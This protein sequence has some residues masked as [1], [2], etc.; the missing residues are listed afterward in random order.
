M[1]DDSD[2][3]RGKRK[4][5]GKKRKLL[6]GEEVEVLSFDEGL[7]GSWHLAV[8]VACRDSCRWVEYTNLLNDNRSSKLVESIAVSAAIE[9]EREVTSKYRRGSIRPLPPR[10]S[11]QP[12][13]VRYGLCVD[14]LLD[15]AWWEG[16]V[17]DHREG[18]KERKVFF[19]DQGDQSIV[20]VDRLRVT[21][22][23]DEVSEEWKPRGEWLFLKVIQP[24]EEKDG[25]PVSIREIWYD[26]RGQPSFLRKI[27][28]WTSGT[29]LLWDRLVS[30]LIQELWS[31]DNGTYVP[32][33]VS[34]N[35]IIE[36]PR[37]TAIQLES[38]PS[39]VGIN[40]PNPCSLELHR[41]DNDSFLRSSM[42][43]PQ[44][45]CAAGDIFKILPECAVVDDP[46]G[47]VY[48][49]ELL[50]VS[51]QVINDRIYGEP[52]TKC[53]SNP[54]D[55]YHDTRTIL[56]HSRTW[57]PVKFEAEYSPEVA[58]LFACGMENGKFTP[59]IFRPGNNDFKLKL[60][61]HLLKLGW[62]IQFKRDT[63][64]RFRYFSPE[65]SCYYSLRQLCHKLMVGHQ[66]VSQRCRDYDK[67][68]EDQLGQT[69]HKKDSA[70][71]NRCPE[72]HVSDSLDHSWQMEKDRHQ[73]DHL[74][75]A[76][77][78][79]AAQNSEHVNGNTLSSKWLDS[80][81]P[82][83]SATERAASG[84][85]DPDWRET[86]SNDYIEP[87]YIP[88]AIPKYLDYI[89]SQKQA[90]GKRHPIGMTSLLRL[91]AKKH[92][93]S[94]GWK[95]SR[96]SKK[97]KKEM[98][99]SSPEGKCFI[100]LA[101]AC[102]A[103]LKGEPW[104]LPLPSS[105]PSEFGDLV[106]GKLERRGPGHSKKRKLNPSLSSAP[107]HGMLTRSS[108]RSFEYR[109]SKK[110]KAF[111]IPARGG[112][113]PVSTS[114]RQLQSSTRKSAKTV[115]SW[116]ID[117]DIVL[118]REK[119]TYTCIR[120]G[121][122]K[123]GRI[124]R[125]GIKCTCCNEVFS[126]AKFE[127]HAGNTS[128]RPSAYIML[129]DGRS[130]LQC[131]IQGMDTNRPETRLKVRLKGDY[132]HFESDALCSIC[133]A[134]GE[135]LLCDCCPSSFHL[136][137]VGLQVTPEGNWFCPSCRCGICGSS[138][139]NC[140]TMQ[141]METTVMYCDQC[142][143][144]YHVGCLEKKRLQQ[145]SCCPSGYW[146]CSDKCSKIFL[147][148]QNLIG[149]SNMTSVEGLSWTIL[150]SSRENGVANGNLESLAEHHSKLSIA[151]DVLHECFI[152]M[153]EPRTGSD[154]VADLLFNR[155]SELNRL[156]FWGF[157]TMLLEKGDELIAVA[158]FRV[159][160]EKVA[161]MPLVGT[162]I[163]HRRRGMCRLLVGELEKLLSALEVERLIL[164]AVPQLLG[165]WTNSFGFTMMTSSERSELIKYALLNFEGTTMCQK[166]INK[167]MEVPRELTGIP[168]PSSM[169]QRKCSND[170]ITSEAE[171]NLESP[172]VS[173]V[174][175]DEL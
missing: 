153:T 101:T 111:H 50:P 164:P 146:F 39:L 73:K 16:V 15:D 42:S 86:S 44:G 95:L 100:S 77:E 41:S 27:T 85:E 170:T 157:Y 49:M 131:L 92:L 163:Q 60:R 24:Y 43:L 174:L 141:F 156:N 55:E 102:E 127:A 59:E 31:V 118:P 38:I 14:A 90:N 64:P 70:N 122:L 117:H 132:S 68:Q 69:S 136:E 13:D 138:E 103:C 99:Y 175:A 128:P 125:S 76:L 1:A 25:L 162:R 168:S 124:N 84:R 45:K 166:F 80:D 46:T 123:E 172:T 88:E 4:K 151:L 21:L 54:T 135:L 89:E 94:L 126:L 12:V 35:M 63:M 78:E 147:H 22:L 8:V 79:G 98:R 28:T 48:Q 56:E 71:T 32:E 75:H 29:Q 81:T 52:Q 106:L 57:K 109:K 47:A 142:E 149:K 108:A 61:K 10:R 17:F 121:C 18:F 11:M 19:P 3:R 134:G 114:P 133:Q 91:N 67:F 171:A 82:E 40:N 159:Y 37:D 7:Y 145:L 72:F 33:G 139:Y 165:T 62:R 112:Y 152:P 9:G 155:E 154:L 129:Q 97:T 143:R 6:A 104:A 130:L 148:L 93:L 30:D 144:E 5:I 74:S 105:K 34:S 167:A 150:R 158:T 113:E 119:V 36:V 20:D 169:K 96:K 120:D 161:E 66:N 23:W 87:K 58:S 110:S 2:P 140:D 137:C 83:N 160:G 107:S 116:L 173:P 65:G 53:T 51:S 26:L 115:L